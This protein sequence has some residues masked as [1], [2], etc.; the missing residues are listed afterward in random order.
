MNSKECAIVQ[1][2]I[3]E[4]DDTR[5]HYANL[6][7]L[8]IR[9]HLKFL[10]ERLTKSHVAIAEDLAGQMDLAGGVT[11][12]RGGSIM[13]KLRARIECLLTMANVDIDL[14]CLKHIAHHEVRVTRRFRETLDGVLGLHQNLHRELCQ[15]E[16]AVFRI[17]ALMREMETPE[18]TINHDAATVTSHLIHGRRG[19]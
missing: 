15:L 18:L 6:A 14:G 4:L 12:R 19:P 9:P 3:S 1:K 5:V 2:L 13:V 11:A 10:V 16:R 8:L 17:E 7:P